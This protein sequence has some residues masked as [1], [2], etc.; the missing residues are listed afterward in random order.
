MKKRNLQQHYP[1]RILAPR[2]TYSSQDLMNMIE[3]VKYSGNPLHKKH[4]G[5]HDL[6]P[7]ARRRSGKS[8]CDLSGIFSKEEALALL[9]RGLE[10]G[11]VSKPGI[12]GWPKRVWAVAGNGMLLE[13]LSDGTGSYH[14][15]PLTV[16]DQRLIRVVE[17]WKGEK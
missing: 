6:I 13:A 9:K 15:Y 1:K 7:R 2:G 3:C 4:R 17:I 12:D 14:G 10:L 16:S 5:N 11:T 8:L